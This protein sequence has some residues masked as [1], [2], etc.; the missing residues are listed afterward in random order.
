[1]FWSVEWCGW[2][3]GCC[4]GVAKMFS[5]LFNVSVWLL[6]W[7]GWLL[8][9]YIRRFSDC[10]TLISCVIKSD[11]FVQSSCSCG[12]T[13]TYSVQNCWLVHNK[14]HRAL[15]MRTLSENEFRSK[16]L[17]TFCDTQQCKKAILHLIS[18][19]FKNTFLSR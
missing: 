9:C 19:K 13:E 16:H 2:L 7:S 11:P 12:K 10:F 3:S 1:M 8:G 15:Y 6:E 5:L 17:R 18:G 14:R 4:Y